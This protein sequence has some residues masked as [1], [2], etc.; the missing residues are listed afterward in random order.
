[1]Q[2]TRYAE[3]LRRSP[4]LVVWVD[5]QAFY[6]EHGNTIGRRAVESTASIQVDHNQVSRMHAE[7]LYEDG[8]WSINDGVDGKRSLNGLVWDESGKVESVPLVH[9]LT[10][11]WLGPPSSSPMVHFQLISQ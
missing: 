11:V 8:I 4:R 6:G 1:M 10:T 2:G 7:L 5:S 3:E 9:Q